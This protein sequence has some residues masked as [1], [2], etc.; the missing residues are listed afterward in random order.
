MSLKEPPVYETLSYAWGDPILNNE[1]VANGRVIKI[2]KHLHTA[3]R[4]LRKGD[5]PRVIWADG[6]CINQSDPDERSFQ[7]RMMGDVYQKGTKLQIWLGEV[8]EIESNTGRSTP[9][10]N[11]WLVRN[12][13]NLFTQ[14]LKSQKLIKT[15]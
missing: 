13:V 4:H 3:L 12:N 10:F 7:V 8:E 15:L 14:F 11:Y 9:T 2:T 5:E 6:I 1:I